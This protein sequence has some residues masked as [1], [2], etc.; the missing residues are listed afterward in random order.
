M[1]RPSPARRLDRIL[2]G[3]PLLADYQARW[4]RET[5]LTACVRASLPRPL[6]A[7]VQAGTPAADHLDL[8]CPSGTVASAVRMRLAVL[9]AAL[10]REGWEFREVRVRVQPGGHGAPSPKP[11]SLQWDK[12]SSAALAPL[13]AAL[14]PGP[15]RDAVARLRRRL[16]R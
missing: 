2:A 16:A 9:T 13:E 6:A 14:A 4:R 11:V 1:T 5:A 15:L 8:V 3:D 12:S 7:L 10:A